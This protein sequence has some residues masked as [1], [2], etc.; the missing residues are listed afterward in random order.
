MSNIIIQLIGVIGYTLLSISFYRKEKKQI[1]FMQIIANAFF[2][3]HYYLL[4]GITGAI[5]NLIGLFSYVLI[6]IFDKYSLKKSKNILVLAMIILL[7]VMTYL[8]YENI[9]SILPVIAFSFTTISF[10]T[11]N[12]DSI[13]KAGI[14]AA[15]CWLTYAIVYVSYAAIVFEVITLI[16]TIM[17]IVY[18]NKNKNNE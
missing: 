8:S 16:A 17:S 4:S 6:Y 12:E 5:T 11:N 1:L 14:V 2:T 3:V 15:I 9:Y 18:S 7:I 10:L 13:R